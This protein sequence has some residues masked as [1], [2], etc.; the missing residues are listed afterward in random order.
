MRTLYAGLL[1]CGD[2]YI[3]CEY[4]CKRS[5]RTSVGICKESAFSELLQ[6]NNQEATNGATLIRAHTNNPGGQD[7]CLTTVQETPALRA[8]DI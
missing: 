7:R 1:F 2:K 5:T 8:S 4:V 3:S 6:N